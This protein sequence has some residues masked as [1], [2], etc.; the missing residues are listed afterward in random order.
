MP[1]HDAGIKERKFS[2]RTFAQN[3]KA[4]QQITPV[5]STLT[6]RSHFEQSPAEEGKEDSR[7][8]V[9]SRFGHDFSNI[10]VVSPDRAASTVAG[11]NS[12]GSP[13]GVA[14]HRHT[15]SAVIRRVSPATQTDSM[16]SN[17]GD[18]ENAGESVQHDEPK[19]GETVYFS[20]SELPPIEVPA[21]GDAI[22][23]NLTYAPTIDPI[24]PPAVPADFGKT[25]AVIQ[26][27]RSSATHTNS[28]FNVELVID[29]VIQY[30]VAGGT[31]KDIASD[32]DPKITQTNYPQV[33]SD[34]TPSATA[35]NAGGLK[36]FK[37]QPPRRQFWAEDLTIKHELYHADDDVKFGRAGAALGHNWLNRQ[38]ARNYY[39]V[40]VLLG[41]VGQ[42]VA[43]KIIAEM[44]PPAVEQRAYDDGAPDYRARARAI[45]AK[46]DAKGYVPAPA[47]QTPN[48]PPATNPKTPSTPPARK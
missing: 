5:K 25:N 29:N 26:V 12:W 3:P 6:G 13:S 33:V 21:Q 37:N 17:E 16:G 39:D 10:P 18:L 43:N 47:Q 1:D 38:T 32:S 45:K 30:W 23:S 44:A 36:L 48:P 7:V 15:F 14:H 9:I 42:M 4:T 28:T 46:G 40:G 11:N 31:R 35:V 2:M 24:P 22:A 20:E 27:N 8:S 41:R 34:L 19:E